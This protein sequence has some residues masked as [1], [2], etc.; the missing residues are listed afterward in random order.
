MTYIIIIYLFFYRNL[1][2]YIYQSLLLFKDIFMV[3]MNGFDRLV[4][5]YIIY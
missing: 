2:T 1:L 4:N 5:S 3:D